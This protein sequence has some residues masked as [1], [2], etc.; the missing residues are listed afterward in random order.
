MD[1]TLE[2]PDF[3]LGLQL[4][5]PVPSYAL[6]LT[7]HFKDINKTKQICQ[8]LK[9]LLKFVNGCVIRLINISC[10]CDRSHTTMHV[11]DK[12]L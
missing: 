12:D 4:N 2:N 8:L 5:L 3:I 6:A 11:Y 7:I 1:I 9:L 10:T